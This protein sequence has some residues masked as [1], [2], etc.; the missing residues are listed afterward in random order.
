MQSPFD[1]WP[2]SS[3]SLTPSGGLVKLPK[4]LPGKG[5]HRQLVITAPVLA[6][7]AIEVRSYQWFDSPVTYLD[8]SNFATVTVTSMPF[9]TDPTTHHWEILAPDRRTVYLC[10]WG[11]N[12][13]QEAEV[14]MPTSARALLRTRISVTGGQIWMLL[15]ASRLLQICGNRVG[16]SPSPAGPSV[17]DNHCA[18]TT[19]RGS[20]VGSKYGPA[21]DRHQ[22]ARHH[23]M[24]HS[25]HWVPWRNRWLKHN[26]RAT[27]SN[28]MWWMQ[29]AAWSIAMTDTWSCRALG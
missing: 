17:N 7:V 13:H 27:R 21:G 25:P 19:S 28:S 14:I 20:A 2:G 6:A 15:W 23:Q 11:D 18:S 9:V 10:V 12:K 22:R 1:D 16:D 24:T 4:V 8:A 3:V 26:Y 5:S 29:R